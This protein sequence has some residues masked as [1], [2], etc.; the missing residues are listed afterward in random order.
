VGVCS[1]RC[2]SGSAKAAVLP[3]P[4]GASTQQ[5]APARIAGIARSWTGVGTCQPCA[6]A[7]RNSSE[8]RPSSPKLESERAP[9]S[10]PASASASASAPAS[11]TASA[12]ASASA[13]SASTAAPA[14]PSS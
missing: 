13:S 14:S 4:V 11:A 6:A 8:Q 2:T 7:A 12:T 9:G 10:A 1:S 3:E 5:S